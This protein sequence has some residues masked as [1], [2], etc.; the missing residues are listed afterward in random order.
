MKY[1][2]KKLTFFFITYYHDPRLTRKVGGL[3]RV[4]DL[5]D[6]LVKSG[7]QVSLFL[8]K[9]GAPKKQTLARVEE[10]PFVDIPLLRP[11]SFHLISTIL[12]L[13]NMIK[14]VDF[15]YV[16]QMNSF[17]PL[18]LAKLFRIPTILEIPNDPYLA[19]QSYSLIK[20]SIIRVTDRLSMSMADMIIVLS[21]WSRQRLIKFGKIPLNRISVSPSGTDTEL[22]RPLSKEDCCAKLGLDPAFLYVGFVGSFLS[23]QGVDTLIDSAPGALEKCA[24]LRFLLVGIY[25]A[26][27]V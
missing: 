7:H 20:S 15:L 25:L 9:I 3:I 14:S 24:H 26:S 8:P 27:R 22:F 21:E 13:V 12:L 16:R 4:F 2:A 1:R 10:V 11:L 6:N 18:F 19:Y 5:A 17:L 23:H